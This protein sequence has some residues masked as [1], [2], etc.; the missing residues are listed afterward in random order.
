MGYYNEAI[1]NNN[2]PKGENDMKLRTM[3][4]ILIAI[5]ALTLLTG[6]AKA[7][8]AKDSRPV[9]DVAVIAD[10][11]RPTEEASLKIFTVDPNAPVEIPDES[12]PLASAYEGRGEQITKREAEAFAIA[13]AGLGHD[14]ISFLYTKLLEDAE[15]P[16]Y[17]VEFKHGATAYSILVD[18]ATGEILE[19]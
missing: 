11:N 7:D 3:I 1:K 12:V 9:L 15:I 13:H 18:A 14:Q 16:C 6:C 8:T 19:P 17:R 4:A 2:L 5:V 10:A